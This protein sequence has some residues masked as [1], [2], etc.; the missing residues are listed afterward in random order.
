M[1]ER[2]ISII[3]PCFNE[4]ENVREVYVQVRDVLSEIG[5]YRYE[6]IF[7]DN[8]STDR[9][10]E[11]LKDIAGKDV[12]V[13]IIVNS[14][15]FGIVR[16][17]YY[18]ILQSSGDAVIVL[19]ADLQDPPQMIKD[20]VKKWEE[21]YNIVLAVKEKSEESR[22]MFSIR[23]LY[24]FLVAKLSNVELVSNF[25]GFALY[26][27]RVVEILRSLNDPYPDLRS[28]LGEM[29]FTRAE[30]TYTQPAR[31][32]GATKNNFYQLYD[33]AM[34]G[35]TNHSKVPLRLAVMIGF[36]LAFLNFVAAFGYLIYK[37]LFWSSFSLGIA[38]VVIGLFFFASVQLIFIG[39]IGEYIGAIHTQVYR[40]PLVVEKERI[41]FQETKN[42]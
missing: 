41:N 23:K 36:V 28:Q 22:I 4:E 25:C 13:K 37:L 42:S 30:L 16:S 14:R 9:T 31:K 12:N 32:A 8:A 38:P 21:G 7:I 40:R 19:M 6:H 15:N 5:G 29:G 34:L 10:L 27:R 1:T 2:L 33:Q 17:P 24:Y 11:I 26:D 39:I 35:F 3:T 20:F 18:A